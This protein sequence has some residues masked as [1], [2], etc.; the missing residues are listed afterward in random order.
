MA[1]SLKR[2]IRPSLVVFRHQFGTAKHGLAAER[3]PNGCSF[4]A[5]QEK[6]LSAQQLVMYDG[7][8][9]G[10]LSRAEATEETVLRHA[11]GYAQ[12]LLFGPAREVAWL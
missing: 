12:R 8:M 6:R 5:R 3:P 1:S 2:F 7:K 10:V 9:S 11:L 4:A